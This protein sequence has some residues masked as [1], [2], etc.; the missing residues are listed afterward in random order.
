MSEAAL[1][2]IQAI[3]VRTPLASSGAGPYSI[4][5]NFSNDAHSSLL[6]PFAVLVLARLTLVMLPQLQS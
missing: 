3:T 1:A 4:V 2:G 6:I 5:P